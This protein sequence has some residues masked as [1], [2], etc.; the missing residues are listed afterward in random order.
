MEIGN[1]RGIIFWL[2]FE[3]MHIVLL[4][5]LHKN[6]VPWRVSLTG[7][8]DL[9]LYNDKSS[10]AQITVMLLLALVVGTMSRED[11]VPSNKTGSVRCIPLLSTY[12]DDSADCPSTDQYKF[13]PSPEQLKVN[14][15]AL[16]SNVV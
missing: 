14:V 12:D 7:S 9:W 3:C 13:V 5:H 15:D 10:T 8:L 6:Y 1:N 2:C 11:T 4:L 16:F